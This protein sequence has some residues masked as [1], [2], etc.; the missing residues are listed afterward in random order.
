[1]SRMH[2]KSSSISGGGEDA[3][4]WSTEETL[5]KNKSMCVFREELLT[6]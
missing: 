6:V 2:E 5:M 4:R 1:M 3:D